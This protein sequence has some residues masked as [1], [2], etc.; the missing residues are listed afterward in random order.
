M[1]LA[2]NSQCLAILLS[3]PSL[4]PPTPQFLHPQPKTQGSRKPNS[5]VCTI[6]Q[7][8]DL[9]PSSEMQRPP[10]WHVF[11]L[12]AATGN[13]LPGDLGQKFNRARPYS[14]SVLNARS[15]GS[16]SQ[17]KQEQLEMVPGHTQEYCP[18]STTGSC[19]LI[20]RTQ[21]QPSEGRVS[22]E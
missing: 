21:P 6:P 13:V 16:P 7:L 19:N 2:C 11:C 14:T 9:Y 17:R 4:P 18:Q 5:L 1:L 12:R 20:A 8:P 3:C 10:S 15:M 22:A